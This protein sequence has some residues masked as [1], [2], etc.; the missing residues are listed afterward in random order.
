MQQ[1]TAVVL[2][3]YRVCVQT[4]LPDN[5]DLQLDCYGYCCHSDR[6]TMHVQCLSHWAPA[7]IGPYSQCVQVSCYSFYLSFSKQTHAVTNPKEKAF[8]NIV[9]KGE[10]ANFTF[11]HC[12]FKR[13]VW[14]TCNNQGWERVN[15]SLWGRFIPIQIES[16]CRRQI[17]CDSNDTI[18]VAMG[19]W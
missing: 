5:V 7:N 12:I 17:K 2:I 14:Q 16:V 4:N 8:K 1:Q 19:R 9:G 10:N 18:V 11:S 13:L 15:S 6:E 3:F